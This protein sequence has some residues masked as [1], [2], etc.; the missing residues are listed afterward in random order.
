[1]R[2]VLER[3]RAIQGQIEKEKAAARLAEL[4]AAAKAEEAAKAARRAAE[5]AA[6]A[7]AELEEARRSGRAKTCVQCHAPFVLKREE[8]DFFRRRMLS[9]PKRC[10]GCRA[11][12]RYQ[13]VPARWEG[14]PGRRPGCQGSNPD[15]PCEHE[16]SGLVLQE[17]DREELIGGDW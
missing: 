13:S 17:A 9:I 7:A 16:E 15:G 6:R 2:E 3:A 11:K 14:C 5:E 12:R 8:M 1:M 4:A 10:A